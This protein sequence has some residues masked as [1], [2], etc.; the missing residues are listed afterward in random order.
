MVSVIWYLSERYTFEYF[1]QIGDDSFVCL[2]SLVKRRVAATTRSSKQTNED[3]LQAPPTPLMFYAGH[4]HSVDISTRINGAYNFLSGA[5]AS[6]FL[7]TPNIHCVAHA[8]ISPRRWFTEGQKVDKSGGARWVNN[9]RFD[10]IDGWWENTVTRP[11]LNFHSACTWACTTLT[12]I[13]W[14]S[15]RRQ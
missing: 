15:Y 11:E 13:T 7:S 9:S 10:Q 5:L 4:R 12:M 2:H 14:R 8:G 6:R 1:F 3:H